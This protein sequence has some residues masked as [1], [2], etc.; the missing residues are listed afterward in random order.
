[1]TKTS[2]ATRREIISSLCYLTSNV[3][4]IKFHLLKIQFALDKQ[5]LYNITVFR[6]LKRGH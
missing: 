2:M 3:Q 1:M 6:S 4:D 5:L